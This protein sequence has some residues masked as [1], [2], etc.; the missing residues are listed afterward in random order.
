[1]G[2]LTIKRMFLW[3]RFSFGLVLPLPNSSRAPPISA[4][5]EHSRQQHQPEPD[6]SLGH[7]PW[8][9]AVKRALQRADVGY[10]KCGAVGWVCDQIL[11]AVWIEDGGET[12]GKTTWNGAGLCPSNRR[13]TDWLPVRLFTSAQHCYQSPATCKAHAHGTS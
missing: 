12:S 5:V 10:G 6:R 2:V 7:E 3:V 1:M 4:P 11:V 13:S 8:S 9:Y